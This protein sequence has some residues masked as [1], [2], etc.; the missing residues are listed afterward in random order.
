M[1]TKTADGKFLC[2]INNTDTDVSMEAKEAMNLATKII[3]EHETGTKVDVPEELFDKIMELRNTAKELDNEVAEFI[4]A[5]INNMPP[6]L[7]DEAIEKSYENLKVCVMIFGK[8]NAHNFYK[9]ANIYSEIH[10][11]CEKY[12]YREIK[13]K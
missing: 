12:D 5:F 3:V 13:L 2:E 10:E 6:N 4:E 9:L 1:I 11:L 8:T 7:E